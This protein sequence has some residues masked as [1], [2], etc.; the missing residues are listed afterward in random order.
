MERML[1]ATARAEERHFWF[2]GLRRSARQLLERALAGRAPER[3]VDCG[4][5]T[6]RNLGWLRDYGQAVGV[7]RSPIGLGHARRRGLPVVR[8]TVAALPFADACVD[9][10]TSFDVLYCLDADDE[11]RAVREMFRILRP[12]GL[13]LVNAAALDVLRGSHSTLTHEVRRYTPASLR[14]LLEQA[15]F[16]VE[17]MTFTNMVTFPLTLAV[18]VFDR[19]TGRD[20]TASDSELTVPVAPVNAA[21][22]GLLWVEALLL[23]AVDLPIGS[24]LLCVAR[25][26]DTARARRVRSQP[27]ATAD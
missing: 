23:R 1:E 11:A 5:G 21:L 25:K 19:L 27:G 3:I 16:E 24:S 13:V 15:G 10:A 6:G 14:R 20:A 8:A 12:G 9:V 22:D 2:V 26:P 7:E 18:R 17:R 4:A